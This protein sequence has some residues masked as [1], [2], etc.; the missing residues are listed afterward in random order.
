MD[1]DAG[2]WREAE[3]PESLDLIIQEKTAK[4]S[5]AFKQFPTTLSYSQ[6]WLVLIDR[7]TGGASRSIVMKHDWDKVIVTH[8]S[9]YENAY[10]VA[11]G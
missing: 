2:G 9:C 1:F 8:P 10:E 7:M 5:A 11:K 6:W 4:R 3:V